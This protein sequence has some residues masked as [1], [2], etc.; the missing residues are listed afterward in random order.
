MESER[1]MSEYSHLTDRQLLEIIT[2]ILIGFD[3]IG[4]IHD[5]VD[6]QMYHDYVDVY[7]PA[8][9]QLRCALTAAQERLEASEEAQ[10]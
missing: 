7:L 10:S 3:F 1:L 8:Y 5:V 6:E 2:E 9:T 4:D